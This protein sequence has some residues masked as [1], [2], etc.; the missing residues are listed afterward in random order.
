MSLL[1]I[2]PRDVKQLN[3]GIESLMNHI[4]YSVAVARQRRGGECAVADQVEA[5]LLSAL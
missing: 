3:R 4:Q 5:A 1:S 2:L